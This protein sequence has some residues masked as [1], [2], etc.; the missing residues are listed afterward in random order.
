MLKR[1]RVSAI[2]PDDPPWPLLGLLRIVRNNADVEQVL[3]A[4]DSRAHGLT[5]CTGSLGAGRNNNLVERAENFAE[6]IN[7]IH[8]RNVTCN[9]A[10]DL[11]E[12]NH[13]EGDVDTFGVMRA[14]LLEQKRALRREEKTS[15]CRCGRIMAI[16]CCSIN[17]GV[18]SI[19]G[20][21]YSAE[22]EGWRNCTG[23]RWE[24]RDLWEYDGQGSATI[25]K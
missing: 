16:S 6:R 8:L 11:I 4:C 1:G 3:Q 9:P 22:C 15:A 19:P 25:R 14:L 23:W 13:L 5:F 10:G 18:I 7:F 24:S 2:P 20:I 21:L 12:D 17:I